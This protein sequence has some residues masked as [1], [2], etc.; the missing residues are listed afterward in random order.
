MSRELTQHDRTC[1]EMAREHAHAHGTGTFG[2]CTRKHCD[3]GSGHFVY[4]PDEG[5]DAYGISMGERKTFTIFSPKRV[6]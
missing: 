3:G 1:I 6:A 5:E 2:V 4:S